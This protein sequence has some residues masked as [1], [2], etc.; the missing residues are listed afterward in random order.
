MKV[1]NSSATAFYF[2]TTDPLFDRTVDLVTA[3]YKPNILTV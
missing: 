1:K 3:G 2:L